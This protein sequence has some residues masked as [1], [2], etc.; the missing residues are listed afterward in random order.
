MQV[1]GFAISVLK[2]CESAKVSISEKIRSLNHNVQLGCDYL[3][4]MKN[5]SG[6]SASTKL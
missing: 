6:L 5:S 2:G 4:M 3:R 1:R